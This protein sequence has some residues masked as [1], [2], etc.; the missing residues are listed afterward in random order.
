MITWEPFLNT[1][2][3][4]DA[5]S[6]G[7][8]DAYITNFAQAAH[9][10]DHLVYLRFG[11]EMNGNWYPWDGFHNGGYTAPAKYIAAWRHIHD[12]FVAAGASKVKFVWSPNHW[13]VPSVSWNEATDYYPG[14]NYVDWIAIDGYNWGEG[15]WQTFSDIFDT[16]Y[17]NLA[18]YDKPMMIGEFANA[19]DDGLNAKSDWINQAFSQIKSTYP[20]IQIFCWFNIDK[21]RDWRINSSPATEAAF[22]TAIS[23]DYFLETIP[24]E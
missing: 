5:I 15:S 20:K 10:W 19:P 1:T 18:P 6:R 21:E 3:T 17:A 13:S 22:R 23:D 9:D 12:I 11:H 4:L 2:N 16:A 24:T 8:Y 7:D 14:N